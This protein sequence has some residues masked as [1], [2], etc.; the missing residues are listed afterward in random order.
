MNKEWIDAETVVIEL[1]DRQGTVDN[2]KHAASGVIGG[3]DAFLSSVALRTKYEFMEE[4]RVLT[5]NYVGWLPK[6]IVYDGRSSGWDTSYRI[7]EVYP[8]GEVRVTEETT[9]QC[10]IIDIKKL[11]SL[12]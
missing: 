7:V 10:I 4:G 5:K 6:R 12:S 2:L 3:L 11:Y 8:E 1:G 9:V